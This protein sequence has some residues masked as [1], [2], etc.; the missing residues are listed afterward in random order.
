MSTWPTAEWL[1]AVSTAA[2]RVRVG[3]RDIVIPLVAA[4]GLLALLLIVAVATNSSSAL[5][6][7]ITGAWR[8]IP[9]GLRAFVVVTVCL[10]V[11]VAV[12]GNLAT[13]LLRSWGRAVRSFGRDRL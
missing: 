2:Q 7:A 13:D 3:L 11:G 12:L 5:G 9:K 4:S 6:H 1:L 10:G 8:E